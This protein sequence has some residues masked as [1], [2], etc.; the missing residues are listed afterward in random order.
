MYSYPEELQN[1]PVPRPYGK[2]VAIGNNGSTITP[3]HL[4]SSF[5]SIRPLSAD[6]AVILETNSINAVP[7]DGK[8]VV[9][10]YKRKSSGG[11]LSALTEV[12]TCHFGN[13]DQGRLEH[14]NFPK[15]WKNVVLLEFTVIGEGHIAHLSSI[16]STAQ[17]S[18]NLQ[19]FLPDVVPPGTIGF[20][21]DNFAFSYK[22][23]RADEED[24]E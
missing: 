4:Y 18:F 6:F 15:Q 1:L 9:K 5:D 3:V 17:A 23:E 19:A 21:M 8:V 2:I 24:K 20:L 10:A 12:A 13:R 22:H 11:E 16:I 14:C 7:V